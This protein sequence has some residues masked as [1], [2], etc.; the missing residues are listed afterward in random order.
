MI[1]KSVRIKNFRSIKDETIEFDNYT[2]FV[3][4][5][6]SGKSNVLYALNVFFGE[7][8][9]SG[10]DPRFLGEEDFH[11]RDTNNPIEIIVKFDVLTEGAKED[12]K[13]YV[14]H[15]QLVVS[16]EAHFDKTTDRAEVKQFGYRLAI[17]DFAPFFEAEKAKEKVED[18]KKQYTKIREAY[19]ELPSPG[20]KAA[21]IDALR[22]YEE[23]H[24]D[25]CEE[26]PSSDE[27][28]GVSK[29]KNYL[30]KY[31]QWIYVPA[32]KD[33]ATEHAEGKNTALGRLLA[34]TV[35]AKVNFEKPLDDIL[36][37]GRQKY[38]ELL[39]D[40]QDQLEEISNTLQGR[41]AH[42]AHED[43]KL[44]LEWR[45]DAEKAVS[46]IPPF[47]QAIIGEGVFEG[48]LTRFGHGLQRSFLLALLQELSGSDVKGGP[49]LIL[50]C[51]EPELYQHPPQARHLYN[52]LLNLSEENSQI[53]IATHSPY[54]ISGE[55]FEKV[56]LV[57]KIGGASVL[58][59]TT[60]KEVSQVIASATGDAP[61]KPPGRLAK[62]HQALQPT[63]SEMFFSPKVVFTE[64][65][66]DVAYITTYLHLLDLWDEFRKLGCHMI[67]T[68][69][70]S[71]MIQPLAVTKSLEIPA[72]VVFD[73]D[74]DKRE[75][76][77]SRE[78]HRKDN[79][80]ILKLCDIST[81]DPFPSDTLWGEHV[82]MW[83]SDI[84]A[85]VKNDIGESNWATFSNEANRQYSN[86]GDL[87]KNALY[88]ASVLKQ[89]WKDEKRS[90]SLERVCR[91]ILEFANRNE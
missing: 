43:A 58:S 50:A 32:V 29:G 71:E 42:W 46:I 85:V 56:R 82:V 39:M 33:A 27:F 83:P 21:M 5:N 45:Q 86:A 53:L 70:K 84:A 69:G 48:E 75:R 4:P 61:I 15:D 55:E 49:R 41:L 22:S 91:N 80:A 77:G 40:S 25:V 67:P 2:C 1:V 51:E 64:G 78:K 34:R 18:L 24:V 54:F 14:R 23:D 76:N 19:P 73:S 66:E 37:D 6:G 36:A 35:R 12:F 59:S 47:A 57:R 3:G 13:H 62:I 11:A 31:I 16:A 30:E 79:T 60:H 87:H 10:L 74:D 17:K 90:Q 63:L 72:F 26:L 38:D 88:I 52:V 81:P 8:D 89:A 44:R 68:H 28:Y 65:L 7:S 20:T 9:I